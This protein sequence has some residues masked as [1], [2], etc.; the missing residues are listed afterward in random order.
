[1]AAS[2][3]SWPSFAAANRS[4]RGAVQA[5]L[6]AV[7]QQDAGAVSAEKEGGE[8]TELVGAENRDRL[9]KRGLKQTHA[10]QSEGRV[11]RDRG[12]VIRDHVRDCLA[13]GGIDDR[14]LRGL[15][16]GDDAVAGLE[17]V[18]AFAYL[19]Y[20]ADDRGELGRLGEQEGT[21]DLDQEA[22]GLNDG[23]LGLLNG[24]LVGG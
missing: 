2:R 11:D 21:V 9:A 8:Q 1:M 7:Q 5:L 23:G 22:A 14:Q 16:A 10:V 18:D 6:V 19:E 4:E 20:A 3:G 24:D 13:V 17:A 15:G 12:R